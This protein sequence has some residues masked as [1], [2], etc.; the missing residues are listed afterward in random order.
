[1]PGERVQRLRGADV[2]GRLLAAD[3]LLAGLQREH[4]AAAP[5]GVGRLA[6]DPAGHPA[7]VLLGGGEEAERRAAEVEPVAE[8]LALADGDVDAALA[9]RAQDAEGDRVD[10]GDAERAGLVRGRRQR[11]EVLDRAEEVRVLDEDGGDV[12]V[13]RSSASSAGSVTPSREP[14]LDHLGAEAAGVGLERR[15]GVRVQA[16]RDDQPA[17]G[18]CARRAPGRRR[19]RPTTA[20]RTARRWRPAAR[21]APRSRSGT[22]TSPAG[23]PARPRAGRA[24]TGSG[25]PS[26]R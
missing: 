7:Q 6:R 22:R 10:R 12:L 19:R 2:V 25:T 13:D 24:C 26:A 20:P 18:P 23:R 3:V 1:M 17:C 9:R 21:S 5:V 15:A 11:L 14:D 4:E 8:R 16:A